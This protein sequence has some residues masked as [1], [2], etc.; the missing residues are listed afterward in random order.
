MDCFENDD[1]FFRW[2]AQHGGQYKWYK[3]C[4]CE[5]PQSCSKCNN[6]LDVIK[7][8]IIETT[9]NTFGIPDRMYQVV[10][11]KKKES[12]ELYYWGVEIDHMWYDLQS[13]SIENT[14]SGSRVYTESIKNKK[15]LYGNPVTIAGQYIDGEVKFFNGFPRE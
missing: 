7:M 1:A 4:S 8:D 2:C 14:S 5:N 9:Y 6:P 13:F 10:V 11:P 15:T 3:L 12:G